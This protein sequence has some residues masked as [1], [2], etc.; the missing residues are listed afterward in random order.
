MSISSGQSYNKNIDA[1]VLEQ[2]HYCIMT[3]RMIDLD[4]FMSILLSWYLET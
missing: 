2:F 3:F 1:G 4:F